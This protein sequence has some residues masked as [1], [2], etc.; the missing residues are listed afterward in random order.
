MELSNLIKSESV[1]LTIQRPI[2]SKENIVIKCSYGQHGERSVAGYLVIHK[3]KKSPVM[4]R[5]FFRAVE[6][7]ISL[8]LDNIELLETTTKALKS[9]STFFSALSHE[10]RTPLGSILSISQYILTRSSCSKE[11]LEAVGKIESAASH[12]L[13]II[14]DILTIAKAEAGKLIPNVQIFDITRIVNESI[15]IMAPLAETKSLFIKLESKESQILCRTDPKLL[16]QIVINLL[17]NAV[18]YTYEGGIH[19]TIERNDNFATLKIEDSGIGIEKEA[20]NEVFKEFYREYR[21]KE[22]ETGSGLG[23]T[24]SSYIAK[25][26]GMELTINSEGAGKGTVAKLRI[27]LNVNNQI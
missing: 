8:Q 25:I 12:L 22:G 19:I 13:Q 15:D 17:A 11:T 9:K 10:L 4:D 5:R 26:L 23:L 21:V 3:P 20:L 24:I 7:M 2:T 1:E 6:K 27:P 14:N 16:R 18:K